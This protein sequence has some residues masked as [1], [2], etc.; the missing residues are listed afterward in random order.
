MQL[1]YRFRVYPEP[2]QR[3]AL[4]KAFGCARVVWNDGLRDR[5]EA[6]F[7]AAGRAEMPN[8]CGAPVRPAHVPA[9]RV[10]TG[11]SR[12]LGQGVRQNYETALRRAKGAAR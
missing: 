5:K 11:S 4:A 12:T 1:R 8:A 7:V 6:H 2:A 10:E 9:Q 3:I